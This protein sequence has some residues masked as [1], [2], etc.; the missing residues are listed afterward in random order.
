MRV[1]LRRGPSEEWVVESRNWWSFGW[2][3]EKCFLGDDAY[4]RAYYYAKALKHPHTEE[5]A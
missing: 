3:Y 2:Y 5:V 4:N 1:R